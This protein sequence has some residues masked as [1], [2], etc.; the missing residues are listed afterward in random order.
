MSELDT[1]TDA[2]LQYMLPNARAMEYADRLAQRLI[3]GQGKVPV[4]FARRL[5]CLIHEAEKKPSLWQ[6]LKR[7]FRH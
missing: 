5:V 3:D 7:L 4:R 6:R 2:D 1:L